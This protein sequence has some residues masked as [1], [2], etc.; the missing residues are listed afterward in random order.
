MSGSGAAQRGAGWSLRRNSAQPVNGIMPLAA[1]T[2]PWQQPP[3]SCRS[4]TPPGDDRGQRHNAARWLTDT[5]ASLAVLKHTEIRSLTMSYTLHSAQYTRT[6][7]HTG[8][9]A[10]EHRAR[11]SL[12][13][14]VWNEHI[15]IG[16]WLIAHSAVVREP[17]GYRG[18]SPS[19][20][21]LRGLIIYFSPL[22]W[23]NRNLSSR[24]QNSRNN[25]R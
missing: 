9:V 15:Q 16:R 21:R 5:G 12:T 6:E 19:A 7:G 3:P 14:R 11:R 8:S 2:G 25:G 13:V 20:F 18:L 1:A 10:L 23:R 24:F 17:R 4:Q 22:N